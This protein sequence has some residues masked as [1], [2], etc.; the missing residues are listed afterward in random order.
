MASSQ[1][2]EVFQTFDYFY[3]WL[4]KFL[5]IKL[6]REPYDLI[7]HLQGVKSGLDSFRIFNFFIYALIAWYIRNLVSWVFMFFND[8]F[9][10][11]LTPGNAARIYC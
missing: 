8:F 3:N 6:M 5:V 11:I 4:T 9:L 1:N 10:N 2:F 7:H